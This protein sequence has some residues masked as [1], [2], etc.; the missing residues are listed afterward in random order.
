[1][2]GADGD[3]A[4]VADADFGLLAPDERPPRAGRNRAQDGMFLLERLFFGG[5]RGGTQLPVDFVLVDVWQ[6][7]VQQVVGSL[8]FDDTVCRQQ[9]WEAFLPVMVA[10]FD[11]TF[12][13]WS[14]GVAKGDAV[15]ME[16]GTELGEGVR[17]VGKKEGV[18]VDIEG[19]GQTVGLEGASQEVEMSQEGFGVIKA[20]PDIVTGG[21]I[22]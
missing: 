16:R 18:V 2:L 4:I 19:Q 17:G 6:Q 20:G 21:I 13:L 14:R 12:C 10:A 7:L 3:F 11:F 5:E 8:Q 9:G 22:Q 1:V 15:E